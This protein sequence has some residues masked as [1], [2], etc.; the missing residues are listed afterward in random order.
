MRFKEFLAEAKDKYT[1]K[2]Y[3]AGRLMFMGDRGDC[4]RFI[5]R[6]DKMHDKY[7]DMRIYDPQGKEDKFWETTPR[8]QGKY[9]E[10]A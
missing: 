5:E 8:L 3:G 4:I 2:I 6:W 7:T 10:V 9:K 1:V